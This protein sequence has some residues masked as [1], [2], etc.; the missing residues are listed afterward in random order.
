[1]GVFS[2]FGGKPKDTPTVVGQTLKD[3]QL[4]YIV[5]YL[6]ENWLVKD[7]NFISF[8]ADQAIDFHLHSDEGNE[9]HLQYLEAQDSYRVYDTDRP[10]MGYSRPTEE[11]ALPQVLYKDES[12]LYQKTGTGRI[13]EDLEFSYWEYLNEE[14]K[15]FFR[16]EQYGEHDFTFLIGKEVD[17]L[18]FDIVGDSC[19]D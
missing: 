19:E 7:L 6:G 18:Y 14:G 4:N 3:I 13:N 5:E 2:I 12:Y 8:G 16:I 17:P 11:M 10:T 15:R 9:L 1:M